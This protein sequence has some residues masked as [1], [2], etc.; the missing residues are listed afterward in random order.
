MKKLLSVL[1]CAAMLLSNAA[2]AISPAVTGVESAE[3]IAQTEQNSQQDSGEET[4]ELAAELKKSAAP[5]LNVFT[6]Q[7]GVWDFEDTTTAGLT[8]IFESTSNL[9]L[10]EIGTDPLDSGNKVIHSVTASFSGTGQ[11]YPWFGLTLPKALEAERP[12]YVTFKYRRTNDGADGT[13]NT[14]AKCMW[15]MKNSTSASDIMVDLKSTINNSSWDT[16]GAYTDFTKKGANNTAVSK[17]L[18]E[19]N[20]YQADTSK[21]HYYYDDIAVI[22]GYKITYHLNDGTDAVYKAEYVKADLNGPEYTKYTVISDTPSSSKKFV[23]WSLTRD[24]ETVDSVTISDSDIDLYAVWEKNPADPVLR[25]TFDDGITGWGN[26]NGKNKA[27]YEDGN[28]VAEY[29]STGST[30]AITSPTFSL[31]TAKAKYIKIRVRNLTS[32]TGIH[33][34]FYKKGVSGISEANSFSIGFKAKTDTYQTVWKKLEDDVTTWDGVCTQFAFNFNSSAVGDKMYIDEIGFYEYAPVAEYTF[35]DGAQGWS[36]WGKFESSVADGVFTVNNKADQNQGAMNSPGNMGVPTD[37]VRYLYLKYKNETAATDMKIYYRLTADSTYNETNTFRPKLESNMTEFGE[38][39]F[40]LST[41]P[42]YTGNIVC[43]MLQ[44]THAGK[45]HFD[46]VAFY[47]GEPEVP[48]EDPVYELTL[49]VSADSI[50][51]EN[52]TVTVTPNVNTNIKKAATTVSYKTNNNNAAVKKNDDGTLTLTGKINGDI[53]VTAVSDYD[54]SITADVTVSVSGQPDN[55]TV[56]YGM[57]MFMLGN[58]ILQHGKAESIGWYGNWGMAASAEELD[59]AHRLQYYLSDKY[60]EVEFKKCNFAEFE[61]AIS[62]TT[63]FTSYFNWIKSIMDGMSDPPE[64]I[65]IQMGENANTDNRNTYKA[66]VIQLVK[67][68]RESVPDAS[69]VV[70]TPFWGGAGKVDGMKDAAEE[71]GVRVA[72]LHTLNTSENKAVGKFEHNGVANHPGDTG[73]DNIAKLIYD[74]LNVTL[75]ENVTPAY[76][77]PPTSISIVSSKTTTVSDGE[78]LNLSIKTVPETE[79]VSD[80]FWSVDNENIAVIDENGVFTS[81][82]NGVVTVTAVSKADENVKASLEI[83]VT[84][85]TPCFTLTYDGGAEGVTG[86][87]EANKYAKNNTILS[88]A[89]PVR[90]Y[91]IFNGWTTE[92]GSDKTVGSVN[93]TENTTVYASWRKADLWTF[94]RDG[95][96]DGLSVLNGFN[97]KVSG[98]ILQALAT[99]TDEA[100]GNVLKFVSQKLDIDSDDVNAFLL[101][102]QNSVKDDSTQIKLTVVSTAGTYNYT[103]PV[104]S[105]TEYVTYNFDI[106]DV[107]GIITGFEITP[108]NIDSG[109]T[110]D[111]IAFCSSTITFDKNT[112]DD[113]SGMPEDMAAT[114]GMTLPDKGISRFGYKFAGWSTEKDDIIPVTYDKIYGN[115]T[116]YAV[117][118]NVGHWEFSDNHDFTCNG[119]GT[120]ENGIFSH[121]FTGVNDPLINLKEF[122]F[123]AEDY[124]GLEIRFSYTLDEGK[125]GTSTQVFFMPEAQ[126][127]YSEASSVS[128]RHNG[129]SSD[130]FV[131]FTVDMTGNSNWNGK[132]KEIRVDTISGYGKYSLDYVRLVP[133]DNTKYSG[134]VMMVNSGETLDSSDNPYGNVVVNGGTFKVTGDAYVS[135]FVYESGNIDLSEGTLGTDMPIITLNG[136]YKATDFGGLKESD[137]VVFS[138]KNNTIKSGKYAYYVLAL[139]STCEYAL[140]TGDYTRSR[141]VKLF[142]NGSVEILEDGDST[143]VTQDSAGIRSDNYTGLRLLAN[144]SHTLRTIDETEYFGELYEYGFVVGLEADFEDSFPTLDD[145]AALKAVSGVAYDKNGTDIMFEKHADY[146]VI[147]CVLINI[148]MNKPKLTTKLVMTPYVTISDDGALHTVYG[149][150]VARSVYETAKQ[151]ITDSPD[152]YEQNKTYIDTVIRI[153]EN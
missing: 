46:T 145:V 127:S 23:G 123:N 149:Q 129:N 16:Y 78:K 128:Y 106:S 60:G 31:D 15:L 95:Y 62:T 83:T 143:L 69:I 96:L 24:G 125:T 115:T 133:K 120:V 104:T 82:N 27:S 21:T 34:Y 147:S 112:T 80:V 109:I 85:Q 138:G 72:Y 42:N 14:D 86:L 3:E 12:Y 141:L 150:P 18:F 30:G 151:I 52:G 131:T 124:T 92:K 79:T 121:N 90:E 64:I 75:T 48:E 142:S 88:S 117:W 126:S 61:R 63:D 140:V 1:V 26:W 152:V 134:G 36:A 144:V 89:N 76:L 53:T 6:G 20:T 91:Y 99:D 57:N 73:M 19:V 55:K 81:K 98:G 29:V 114:R 132:I 10:F 33:V 4:A 8:S 70:C 39:L 146:N 103:K 153:C 11:A 58:S 38:T 74:E 17:L 22:P 87:P 105:T 25:W 49:S 54:K 13:Y 7:K 68:L 84:G 94:D 136:K 59:Y 111:E 118:E 110:V 122:T 113:V 50:T 101:K 41:L 2:F 116:V 35:D 108:T 47:P 66:A 32:S 93:V 28:L 119:T 37:Q 40:D 43:F 44:P 148:P 65:T 137:R 135:N 102:I 71:L 97:V 107:S 9:S 45:V 5:G 100:S 51:E 77:C 67:F 139:D 56:Y 130:G